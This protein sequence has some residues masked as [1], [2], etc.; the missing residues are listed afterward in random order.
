VFSLVIRL[1][2]ALRETLRSQF[3]DVGGQSIGRRRRP[4]VGSDAGAAAR[5]IILGSYPGFLYSA[6]IRSV[7]LTAN[8]IRG[9]IVFRH[10][11]LRWN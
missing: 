11:C 10:G 1:R 4:R 2:L 8:Q 3:R 9:M 7:V 6:R 5:R